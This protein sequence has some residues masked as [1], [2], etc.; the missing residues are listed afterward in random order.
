MGTA[1]KVSLGITMLLAVSPVMASCRGMTSSSSDYIR[2][3]L[4]QDKHRH[5]KVKASAC[6]PHK[7]RSRAVDS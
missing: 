4:V 1:T 2:K 5:S 7:L 6:N 3:H